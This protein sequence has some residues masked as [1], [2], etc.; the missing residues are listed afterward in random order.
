MRRKR[1]GEE[2]DEEKQE[3]EEKKKEEEE[4]KKKSWRQ[5]ISL[6]DCSG[7]C[8]VPK[9][10]L[11]VHDKKVTLTQSVSEKAGSAIATSVLL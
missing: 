2:E 11:M 9:W 3:E 10:P 7:C 5:F 6:V 4:K 1:R 8:E